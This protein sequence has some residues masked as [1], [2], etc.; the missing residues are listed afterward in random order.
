LVGAQEVHAARALHFV[1]WWLMPI[2]NG[3]DG[4]AV[5]TLRFAL[6]YYVNTIGMVELRRRE[7]MGV[8]WT[9][10]IGDRL[11]C[12]ALAWPDRTCQRLANPHV[13]VDSLEEAHHA[14]CAGPPFAIE[15]LSLPVPPH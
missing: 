13:A 12:W 15:S 6:L 11:A 3:H 1:L 10:A 9:P 8:D 7:H 2:M 4:I 5:A 14:E